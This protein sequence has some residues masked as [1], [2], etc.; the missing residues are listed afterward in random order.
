MTAIHHAVFK[1]TYL[2]VCKNEHSKPQKTII[3]V[4]MHS[5]LK[6]LYFHYDFCESLQPLIV[7]FLGRYVLQEGETG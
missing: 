1:Y 3:A 4:F 7:S 5:K 6:I 2:P